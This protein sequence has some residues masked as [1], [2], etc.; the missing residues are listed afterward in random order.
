MAIHAAKQTWLVS[1]SHILES[2]NALLPTVL[3]KTVSCVALV[4]IYCSEII[5]TVVEFSLDL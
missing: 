1:L 2:L 4:L 3:T 5:V